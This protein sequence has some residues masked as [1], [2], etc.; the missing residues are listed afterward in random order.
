MLRLVNTGTVRGRVSLP[1]SPWGIAG[2]VI[3]VGLI[4]AACGSGGD[5]NF[6]D[7]RLQTFNDQFTTTGQLHQP[8]AA[9]PTSPPYGGPHSPNLVPCGVYQAP[10][11]FAGIVHTMEH[12]AVIIY[13]QPDLFTPDEVSEVRAVALDL[14]QDGKR[15]VFT[16]HQQI[17]ARLAL[18]AWGRLLFLDQ[19]EEEAIRGF[20]DAFEN[21]GPE[22][23]PRSAAC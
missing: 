14:L 21:K 18:A 20:A 16:P 17:N 1:R 4:A 22:R 5:S 8:P 3:V 19:F 23:I 13:Y 7:P 6:D 11:S 10:Q 15:I 12:G 9:Y 2:L